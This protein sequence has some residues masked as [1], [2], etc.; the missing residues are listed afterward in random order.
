MLLAIIY[1]LYFWRLGTLTAGLSRAEVDA[2]S[3]SSTL[4]LIAENPLYGPH[5][6]LQLLS[7]KIFGLGAGALRIVSAVLATIVLA[8]FYQLVKAWFGRMISIF[9]TLFL[10]VTP[11]FV[12]LARSAG[13]EVLLFLPILGLAS[14]YWVIRSRSW[15][16]WLALLFCGGLVIYLPGGLWLTLLA[17]LFARN[18]LKRATSDFS[19]RS[20]TIGA[21]IFLVISAPLMYGGVVNPDFIKP[22]LLIPADWLSIW[23]TVR[24]IGWSLLALL[25]RAPMHADFIIGRLPMF[26]AAQIALALLGGF[27]LGKLARNKLYLLLAMVVFGIMAAG[28]NRNPVL[29]SF[30]M[31]AIAL[32]IAAGLRY[33]YMEW[34]KVFPRNPLAKYLAL[35]LFTSIVIMHVFYG[36]RYVQSAWPN[37]SATRS[38]Y[39]LK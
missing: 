24:S 17:A 34:R 15:F 19:L 32:S 8:C 9:A 14:Y 31:P 5:K 3:S 6:V 13:P 21:F 39:V 11:W 29:L 38:T 20:K 10:A 27:A 37:S 35:A 23:E 33:L 30:S 4:Q 1:F 36:L 22:L 2:R 7:V 12:L 26:G 16:A 18:N 25:W 28:I